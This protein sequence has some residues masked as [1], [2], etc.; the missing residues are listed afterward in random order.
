MELTAGFEEYLDHVSAGLG[1]S[2]RKTGLK[3]Y[4]QGLMLPLHRKSMEPLAAAIDP[5]HVCARHQSLQ[6]FVA[7]SPWSD[8][9]VLGRV[10]SWVLPKIEAACTGRV[11]LIADDTGMPKSGHHSVGVAPQYCG[12]LGKTANCQVA[13]TLSLATAAASLPVKYR[14]YLPEAWADDRNRCDSSGVPKEVVFATK[15]QISLA[16]IKAV[17]AAGLPGE[18]VSADA[19]YG[20]DTDYRDGIADLGLLY[21]LGIKPGTTVWAP[22][23]G[24]LSPKPWVGRGKKPTRLRRDAEHQPVSVKALALALPPSDY[25]PLSWREGTNKKLS[26]RFAAVRVRAAHRDYRGGVPRDEE[27]L[28]IEWPAGEPEPTKYFLSTLP[29]ETSRQELVAAA[30]IRWRIERDY[31]ELKQEFGLNN[32]EGRNWRGFHHH[33]TL[34]V[35]AYGFLLGE[36]LAQHRGIKKNVVFRTPPTLP[37]NYTRRGTTSTPAP[38]R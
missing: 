20:D 35:A 7:D 37:E 15:P 38:C 11:F 9:D 16:Q 10:Q 5:Y 29:A 19:G 23:T 25:A 13:V 14:L 2:E 36:R 3:H 17:R 27:W 26:S 31:Q 12:Q 6:N 1:R 30:K 24:P 4:C 22:D 33:A 18:I 21:V 32:F 28:L 34:C 8:E